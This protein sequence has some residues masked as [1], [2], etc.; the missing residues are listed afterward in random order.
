MALRPSKSVSTRPKTDL[1]TDVSITQ[2]S[3][4]RTKEEFT[5]KAVRRKFQ[6]SNGYLL[7]FD[8]LARVLHVLQ[9]HG[10]ANKI[11]RRYLQENTGFANRQ[12]AS[13]VS[14]GSALGLIKT[15]CQ[16]LTPTGC[17][18]AEHDLFMEKKSTL[19]WLHYAAAGNYQNL[20]WF[21]IF[22][23]LIPSNTSLTQS[24]WSE[25]LRVKLANQYSEQTIKNKLQPEIH[26]V[27]DAYMEQNL[28]KLELL[29]R[30]SDE[31][32]YIRRYINFN[33]LLLSAMLYDFAAR[34]GAQLLQVGE[35]ANTAGSPARL[36]GLDTTN[37]REQ[38]ER[39]HESGWV[40]YET[41]H[42]LDQIRLKP[43][44]SAREFLAASFEGREPCEGE[45]TASG[46]LVNE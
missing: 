22:N 29:Q 40:R 19:E 11:S 18:I 12:I 24:S 23:Q 28:S 30:N 3:S 20:I 8:R 27:V 38:V 36:F 15:G 5:K 46:R 16:T 44:F 31:G 33:S 4:E 14:I 41:T 45:V 32:L 21:E 37:F 13:I 1:S 25:S 7:E 34:Q 42:N 35:M 39:L 2:K 17:L 9:E 10:D 43:T 6:V 26:F